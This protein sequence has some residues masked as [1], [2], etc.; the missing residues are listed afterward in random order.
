MRANPAVASTVL[1]AAELACFDA[2]CGDHAYEAKA[3]DHLFTREHQ[4]LLAA[5]VKCLREITGSQLA[6]AIQPVDALD[7]SRT[8][9]IAARPVCPRHGGRRS[10]QVAESIR[11]A[12]RPG[13][14][15]P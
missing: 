14:Q 5:T 8:A 6:D 15:V 2:L 1:Q 11:P 13:E 7:F 12:D 9:P 3:F 4:Y 10:L